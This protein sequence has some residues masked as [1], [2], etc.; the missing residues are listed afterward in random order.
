MR[1]VLRDRVSKGYLVRVEI[2]RLRVYGEVRNAC[3][4]AQGSYEI[5]VDIIDVTLA[6]DAEEGPQQCLDSQLSTGNAAP[7]SAGGP[8][9]LLNGI[10][11]ASVVM[12]S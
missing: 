12:S 9:S 4:N 6:G 7:I 2:G 5:D 3:R 10:R 11:R 1:C 8:S